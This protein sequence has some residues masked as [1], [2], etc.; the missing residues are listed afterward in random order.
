MSWR[1]GATLFP[2]TALVWGSN[3]SNTFW[4]PFQHLEHPQRLYCSSSAIMQQVFNDVWHPKVAVRASNVVCCHL[5]AICPSVHWCL[6]ILCLLRSVNITLPKIYQHKGAL[7]FC[8]GASENI[9][10]RPSGKLKRALHPP[11]T[12]DDLL[13]WRRSSRTRGSATHRDF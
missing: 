3:G 11:S 7:I 2:P 8:N 1:I 6:I 4:V 10:S 12:V 5:C 9:W 13:P